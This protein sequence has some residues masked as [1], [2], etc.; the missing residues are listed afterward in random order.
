MCGS[1][2][3]RRA[4]LTFLAQLGDVYNLC[5]KLVTGCHFDALS[6][7][8]EGAPGGRRGARVGAIT[9]HGTNKQALH[10]HAMAAPA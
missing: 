8:A 5:R 9:P 7:D 1:H 3:F 10:S 6:D 4:C 2:R